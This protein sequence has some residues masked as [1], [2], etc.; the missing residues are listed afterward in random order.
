MNTTNRRDF[1]KISALGAGGIIAAGPGMGV[2][3]DKDDGPDAPRYKMKKVPTYCEVCF[4]KCA[5]WIYY[6][7]EG[8]LWKIEGNENDPHCNGRL[9]PRGTGGLGMYSDEDRLKVPLMRVEENGKQTYKEV[10]LHQL[11]L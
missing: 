4:W 3:R 10:N 11:Y 5:G 1:I 9:C 8:N 2:I 7:E 6:N